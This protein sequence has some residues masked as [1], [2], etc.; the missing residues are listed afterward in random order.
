MRTGVLR[1]QEPNDPSAGG[2]E[3]IRDVMRRGVSNAIEKLAP[4]ERERLLAL[5]RTG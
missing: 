2:A 4:G 1:P 5:G 3:P